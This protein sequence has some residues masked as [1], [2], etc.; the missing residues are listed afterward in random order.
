V[1]S[2][3]TDGSLI[4]SNLTNVFKFVENNPTS[5]SVGGVIGYSSSSD[6][7]SLTGITS[8][9][10]QADSMG[11][12]GAI[13]GKLDS[14]NMTLTTA[15]IYGLVNSG[16]N[17]GGVSGEWRSPKLKF[18]KNYSNVVCS[19]NCAGFVGVGSNASITS[20]SIQE[21]LQLGNIYGEYV[22]GLVGNI[23]STNVLS[24]Y[25]MINNYVGGTISGYY[26]SAGLVGTLGTNP[27]PKSE[28]NV[29]A[30][31]TFVSSSSSIYPFGTS[32]HTDFDYFWLSGTVN[33][34][35]KPVWYPTAQA[36]EKFLTGT[37]MGVQGNF[38]NLSF[39][40][41]WN[42]GGYYNFPYKQ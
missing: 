19:N 6:T 8:L 24:T 11:P 23:F 9:V 10:D 27:L 2:K 16:G 20:S 4:I 18:I 41:I 35:E 5:T 33:T 14:S 37:Q 15:S 17:A 26:V 25:V 30:L 22:G 13:A 1:I 28:K 39:P 32:T 3:L 12:S 42:M 31:D 36:K 34:V 40:A 38:S 7:I 21:S 29:V